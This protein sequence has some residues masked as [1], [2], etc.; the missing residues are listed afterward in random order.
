MTDLDVTEPTP[1]V[2]APVDDR[3]GP[4]GFSP[5][6]QGWFARVVVLIVIFGGVFWVTASVKGFWAARISLA[7]IFA[8]IG[9]SLNVVL[10]YLGQLSLGHQA[11]VGISAFV[12]AFYVT[13][14][15]H[16]TTDSCSIGSFLIAVVIA[17]LAG[18]V[19][20]GILGLVALRIRGLYLALITLAYGFVAERSLFE[21]PALTNGGAGQPAPRPD[22]FVGDHAFAYLCFIFLAIVLFIDWRLLRSKVGRAILSIKQSDAVAATYGINVTAYKVLAFMMSGLFA[23]IAGALFAFHETNVVSNN[24]NFSNSLLWVLMV[25]VGGLGRRTGVVIG[26]AFFALFPYLITIYSGFNNFFK[27][28]FHRDPNYITLVIGPLLAVLT[29]IQFPGG[30]AEQIS[31]ITRWLSGKRFTKHPDGGHATGEPKSG[32]RGLFKRRSQNGAEPEAAEPS[33]ELVGSTEGSDA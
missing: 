9:L 19:A 3:P 15:A 18:A 29:I 21:I 28:T 13:K 24:F 8:I 7:V 31:P 11:F 30:I 33:K 27:D 17:A 22:G 1:P 20:A 2:E 16:C 32:K 12:A 10:G 14:S 4:S 26:S 6:P 23:G 5:S 25:V